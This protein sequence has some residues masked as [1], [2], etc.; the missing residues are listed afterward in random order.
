MVHPF[1]RIWIV[2]TV[3]SGIPTSVEGFW[4]EK[5]AKV[6]ARRLWRDSNPEDDEI[7]IFEVRF[8]RGRPRFM[9]GKAAGYACEGAYA[10]TR[11]VKEHGRCA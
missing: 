7:T 2:V 10:G 4:T 11:P 5:R 6:V 8:P 9:A 3:E 1:E